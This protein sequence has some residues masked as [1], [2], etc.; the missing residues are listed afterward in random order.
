MLL[1]TAE[2]IFLFESGL[3]ND[4]LTPLLSEPGF[5]RVAAAWRDH[6]AGPPRLADEVYSWAS[7][8]ESGEVFYLP[9]PGPGDSDGGDIF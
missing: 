2:A 9:T 8:A 7:G 3:G 6:L 4:A 5:W 1:T